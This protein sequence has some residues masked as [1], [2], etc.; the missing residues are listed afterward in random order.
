MCD[1]CAEVG[2]RIA[3]YRNNRGPFAIRFRPDS[4]LGRKYS[5]TP[6]GHYTTRDEAERARNMCTA[7]D[8][9]EVVPS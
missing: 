7:G 9:M 2:V 3:E 6:A 8:D 5:A 4:D 1:G